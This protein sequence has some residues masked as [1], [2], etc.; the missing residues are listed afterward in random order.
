[1]KSLKS[2]YL[3][4]L[5][6]KTCIRFIKD[7]RRTEEVFRISEQMA[8]KEQFQ[9]LIDR[10]KSNPDICHLIESRYSPSK[11]SMRIEDYAVGTLGHSYIKF[12]TE[13]KLDPNFYELVGTS[14]DINYLRTRIR[15]THDLWHVI[16]GFETDNA[17]EAGLSSAYVAQIST[18]VLALVVGLMLIHAVLFDFAN[19]R[20]YFE[21]ISRGWTL[22]KSAFP[23]LS[24]KWEERMHDNLD[25]IRYELGIGHFF[26]A[27]KSELIETPLQK[28]K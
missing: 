25:T 18:P 16:F 12:M 17:G 2:A 27:T 14:T 23:L 3:K 1:M 5:L 4:I 28:S 21:Q 26:R 24:Q 13:N 9:S 19:I 10:A 11:I 8:T 7:P 20:N 22:G 15:E 6:F